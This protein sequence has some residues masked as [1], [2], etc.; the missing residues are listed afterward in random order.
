MPNTTAGSIAATAGGVGAGIIAGSSIG[1]LGGPLGAA[2][3]A[4]VGALLGLIGDIGSGRRVANTMT[5][6]GGPQDIINKQLAAIAASGAS[7]DEKAQAT[8]VAWQGFI[9]ATNQFAAQGKEQAQ[10]AKQAIFQTPQ[11]TQTVQ[12]LGGFDPLGQQYVSQISP[13][14]PSAT[15]QSGITLG[16]I[17]G[18]AAAGAAAGLAGGALF[19]GGT[20]AAGVNAG[21]TS[22]GSGIFAPGGALAG[23]GAA[24]GGGTAVAAPA[25]AAGAGTSSLL[26]RLLPSLVSSGT[27]LLAGGLGANAATAAAGLQ[28]NAAIEAAKIEAA[29]GLQGQQLIS[30]TAANSLD[31]QKQVLAQQ[32]ANAQPWINAGSGALTRI[33]DITSNPAFQWQGGQFTLPT[34]AEAAATPGFQ[35]QLEQGEAALQ[36]YER[37]QGKLLSGAAAK[38]INQYAQGV[39]S[40]NYQNTVGNKLT[41]FNTNYGTFA[42]ERAANLNPQLALAGLG[43]VSTGNLNSNLSTAANLNANT[44]GSAASNVANLGVTT[45]GNVANLGQAAAQAQASGY[46]S[47]GNQISGALGNVGNNITNALTVQQLLAAL[48]GSG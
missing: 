34:A 46:V 22:A 25:I 9:Q 1:G 15:P 19:G 39:A 44:A 8:Q 21:A 36:A 33:G 11:L 16:S 12:S 6:K 7:P 31:F 28:S 4:G 30:Q 45:A 10:V 14:I 23:T 18:P 48:K 42:N 26:T 47:S 38:E 40:T 24:A 27:S 3:G 32:Q 17:L 2:V 29:A 13:V 35:F 20:T 37:S 41:A 43:Q 5:Q